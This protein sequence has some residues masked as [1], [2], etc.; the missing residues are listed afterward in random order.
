MEGLGVK[1][2][3]CFCVCGVRIDEFFVT[4]QQPLPEILSTSSLQLRP[5]IT[6]RRHR[7]HCVLQHNLA[8]ILLRLSSSFLMVGKSVVVLGDVTGRFDTHAQTGQVKRREYVLIISGNRWGL[9]I[10]H[11][12]ILFDSNFESGS[13]AS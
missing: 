12:A 9:F 6:V 3:F 13:A 2:A 8:Q 4:C 7:G 11:P 1:I 10:K 5:K